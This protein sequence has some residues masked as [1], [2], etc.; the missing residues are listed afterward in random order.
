MAKQSVTISF[1][2]QTASDLINLSV[3]MDDA[4]NT[5]ANS[6]RTSS[7]IFGDEAFFRVFTKP[8]SGITVSCYQSDGVIASYGQEFAPIQEYISFTEPPESAGGIIADN[9]ASLSK[10]VY[11]NFTSEGLPQGSSPSGIVTLSLIDPAEVV[12][13]QAGPGVYD[14]N[15]VAQYHSFSIRK[16]SIPPGFPEDESYPIVVVIVGI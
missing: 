6:G 15:Y 8:V 3:D 4:K 10:P 2:T 5:L 12:A 16:D 7:F 11:G 9:V 14:I 1:I 13:S